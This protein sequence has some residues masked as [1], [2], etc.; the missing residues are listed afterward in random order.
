ML[1]APDEKDKLKNQRAFAY[2]G[3]YFILLVIVC[4]LGLIAFGNDGTAQRA[5][6]LSGI[7]STCITACIV[8][9]L[10]YGVSARKADNP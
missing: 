9:L 1:G 6:A 8:P 4:C 10:N 7:I 5:Q 3:F 2:A